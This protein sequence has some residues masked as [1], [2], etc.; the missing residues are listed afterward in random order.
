MDR[1]KLGLVSHTNKKLLLGILKARDVAKHHATP[2]YES[3]ESKIKNISCTFTMQPLGT[4]KAIR[5]TRKT[6]LFLQQ[7]IDYNC[8][9][10]PL[11]NTVT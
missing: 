11:G 1:R 2:R 5:L 10:Y 3:L 4:L 6:T 9:N 7:I 8:L